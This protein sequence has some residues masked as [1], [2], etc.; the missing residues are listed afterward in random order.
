MIEMKAIRDKYDPLADVLSALVRCWTSVKQNMAEK[1]FYINK[2]VHHP[3]WATEYCRD[4]G[5]E[6]ILG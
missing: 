6:K 1:C 3:M 5:S 2:S 4:E